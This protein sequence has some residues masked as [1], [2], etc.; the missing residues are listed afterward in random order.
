VAKRGPTRFDGGEKVVKVGEHA[1]EVVPRPFIAWARALRVWLSF[2]GS[3]VA[4]TELSCSKTVLIS[5]VTWPASR[6]WPDTS[7]SR[8]L[9]GWH[10]LNE[11]GTENRCRGDVYEHVVG[12]KCSRLGSIARRMAADRR[13]VVDAVDLANLHS[14]N[15]T[16]ASG[17][18][19]KPA[20]GDEHRDR[21]TWAPIHLRR[22]RR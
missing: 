21:R 8:W 10:Q 22:E 17:Y 13:Q 5:T 20:R 2:S 11:L 16:L 1:A 14:R 18:I 9:S 6:I 3:I 19:T 15:F 7:C 12:M 4:N